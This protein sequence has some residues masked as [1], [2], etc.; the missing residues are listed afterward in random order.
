M[1]PLSA[2]EIKTAYAEAQ[3]LQA[4][5]QAE[6][7][8]KAYGRIVEARADIPEVHFQIGRLFTDG[9]R[10][11]RAITHLAAAASL[12]PAEPA[13]WQAWADAAA[14]SADPDVQAEFLARLKASAVPRPAQVALQDR[15]GAL[16]AQTRPATGGLPPKEVSALVALMGQ[17]RFAE[18]AARAATLLKK[19]PKAAAVANILGSAQDR[20]GRRDAAEAAFRQAARIDPAYAE[21]QANLG[22]LLFD[23]G[24]TDEAVPPLRFRPRDTAQ[25]PPRHGPP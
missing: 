19:A 23:L 3:R 25:G 7:A 14:L 2:T 8:L 9:F 10:T 13:I 17:G 5:G 6:A 24:R 20:L 21:A 15:F 22:Q 1:T 18:A 11:D 4:S 12:K 16:K